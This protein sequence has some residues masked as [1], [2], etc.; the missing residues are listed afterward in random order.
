MKPLQQ[1]FIRYTKSILSPGTFHFCF[2]SNTHCSK[3]FICLANSPQMSH[4]FLRQLLLLFL[5]FL[6][7]FSLLAGLLSQ[8]KASNDS[9]RPLSARPPVRDAV[10]ISC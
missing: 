2:S 9:A 6:L 10:F 3:P 8:H 1:L 4:Q 7:L 5:S